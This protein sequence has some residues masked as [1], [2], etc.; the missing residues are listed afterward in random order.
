MTNAKHEF[1]ITIPEGVKIKCAIIEYNKVKR[2]L[3]VGYSDEDYTNFL[4]SLDFNYNSGFG[5]QELFGMIWL[6]DG[7]W[8][9][10]GEYDGLEWWELRKLPKIPDE[11]NVDQII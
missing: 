1:L 10:R 2:L 3:K 6:N 5:G 11:L 4:N 9:E 8:I 7:T